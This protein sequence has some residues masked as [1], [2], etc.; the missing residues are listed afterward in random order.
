[1]KQFN[2]TVLAVALLA[3]VGSASASIKTGDSVAAEAYISVYNSAAGKTFNFDLGLTMGELLAGTS[4]TYDLAALTAGSTGGSWASFASGL[5]SANTVYGLAA[6]GNGGKFWFGNDGTNTPAKASTLVAASGMAAKLAGFANEINTETLVDNGIATDAFTNNYSAISLDADGTLGGQ[7]ASFADI[8]QSK[9]DAHGDVPYGT[10]GNLIY[11]AGAATPVIYA[12]GI[13][14][15]G[16]TFT[17][18]TTAVPL[19]A[20]VWLFGAGLMGVLRLN[21]RKSNAA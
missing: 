3:A 5:T 20:A 7:H 11:Y 9:T 21:R 15:Q 17:V 14:L 12:G 4:R 1:M 2:K 10:A 18:A 19:P 13:N 6:A 16:S 8:F